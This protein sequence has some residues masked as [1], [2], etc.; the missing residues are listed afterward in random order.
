MR[1][2]LSLTVCAA[3]SAGCD[4][5]EPQGGDPQKGGDQTFTIKEAEPK[6][7]VLE[8]GGE[9]KQVTLRI[10]R[11]EK[12]ANDV[13]VKFTDPGELGLIVQ[14]KDTSFVKGGSELPVMIKAEGAA[15]EGEKALNFTAAPKGG[16]EITGKVNVKIVKQ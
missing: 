5:S 15:T 1:T 3:L 16:K 11:G 12:F 10:A 4:K 13:K 9:A 8:P 2:L 7:L 14:D 6:Q